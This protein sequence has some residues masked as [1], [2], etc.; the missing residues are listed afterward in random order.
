MS[1]EEEDQLLGKAMREKAQAEKRL[2]LIGGEL[3][4]LAN[5]LSDLGN[6]LRFRSFAAVA[7]PV[8]ISADVSQY[9]EC[10]KLLALVQEQNEL[11]RR[12]ESLKRVVSGSGPA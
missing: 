10:S 6:D 12:L 7:S 8:P 4:R 2:L 3:E 1:Q 5:G 9:M 11:L